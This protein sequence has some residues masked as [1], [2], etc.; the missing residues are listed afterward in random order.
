MKQ[1][2]HDFSTM[3]KITFAAFAFLFCTNAAF[4]QIQATGVT[5]TAVHRA[6]GQGVVLNSGDYYGSG[7]DD[8]FSE[9]GITTFNIS[10]PTVTS[11]ESATLILT[12]NDRSF[13][14]GSE[15]EFFFSPESAADLGGDF[16]NLSY[17]GDLMN[18]LDVSQFGVAPVSLGN[19][20][21]DASL[22]GGTEIAY[23]LDLSAA[24][25]DLL[26]SIQDGTDFQI[27]ITATASESDVTYSGVGNTFDPGDPQL[28]LNVTSIP[29]PASAGLLGLGLIAL[30]GLRRRRA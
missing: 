10:D 12:Y 5:T 13:S 3:K 2:T 29:E 21:F 15:V 7:N 27:I 26:S 23:F 6:D 24:G 22:E 14:D 19:R 20:L 1:I 25:S 28:N 17:N 16:A 11:I 8:N 18:G 30:A 9:Y 4:G